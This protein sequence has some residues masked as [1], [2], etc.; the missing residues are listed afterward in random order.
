MWLAEYVG[1]GARLDLDAF[2][3]QLSQQI[4]AEGTSGMDREIRDSDPGQWLHVKIPSCPL[5]DS[6]R[7]SMLC[8]PMAGTHVATDPGSPSNSAGA[9][10]T[11]WLPRPMTWTS[12]KTS[13][14]FSC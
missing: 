10:M 7:N 13:R 3:S 8:S 12:W 4:S 6:W 9:R 1:S 5:T 14:A 11:G 2:S